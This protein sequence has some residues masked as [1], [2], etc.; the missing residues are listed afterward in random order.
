M[1]FAVVAPD[2][3]GKNKMLLPYRRGLLVSFGRGGAETRMQQPYPSSSAHFQFMAAYGEESGRGIYLATEDGVGYRK[4]F[5]E[6]NYPKQNCVR[7]GLEHIPED[8]GMLGVGYAMP[9][10]V[11]VGPFRG[12]WWHACRRYRQWWRKQVWASKGLICKRRDIPRWLKGAVVVAR[13]S[14]N[15]PARTVAANVAG[16]TALSTAL[17]GRP[18]FGIWYAPFE[19]TGGGSGRAL[20]PYA[21]GHIL[22]LRP[23]LADALKELR[24]KR[25]YVQAYIQSLIYKAS[26]ATKALR[27]DL[28]L[29]EAAAVRGYDG[30]IVLY[31]RNKKDF[32]DMCRASEWWQTRVV[33]LAEHAVK[34]GF[35]GV[36]LDSFGRASPECFSRDHDHPIGGGLA[37]TQGQRKMAQRVLAAIRRIDP[38]AIL[39]GEA[40]VETYRDILHVNLYALN[41]MNGYVPAFRTIWGDYSLGH[42]RT[43]RPSKANDNLVPEL[44]TLFLEGTIFGRFFCSS[45]KIFLLEPE[46]ADAFRF[47]RKLVAYTEHGMDYLRFGEYLHPAQLNPVPSTISYTEGA[48]NRRVKCPAV[49]DSV[50]RSHTDGSVA[51]VVVN[52]GATVYRGTVRVDPRLRS[53]SRRTSHPVAELARMDET[54]K[55]HP[56]RTGRE[57]WDEPLLLQPRDVLF[58]LLR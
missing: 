2:E 1:T 11:V 13:L 44:T 53:A 26:S 35:A 51:I 36:Y 15:A 41:A 16:A 50:T 20:G 22:P 6:R 52:C 8:R 25:V 14:C 12:D 43:V 54:G 32:Y 29:A 17:G 33:K 4:T 42:G 37:T 34:M 31:S 55:C 49:M 24:R 23:G 46:Y 30:K 21:Y 47:F 58:L 3:K 7:L 48:L 38:E 27:E 5:C 10:D 57:A 18:L 40:P 45:G 19:V 9:Y 56:L 39:S 28:A